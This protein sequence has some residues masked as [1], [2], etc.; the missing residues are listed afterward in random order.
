[1]HCLTFLF[2]VQQIPQIYSSLSIIKVVSSIILCTIFIF[3][4]SKGMESGE[5]ELILS[6]DNE[7]EELDYIPLSKVHKG[8][9]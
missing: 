7:S 5:Y 1:M 8:K 9:L 4:C 2:F 3:C 6:S